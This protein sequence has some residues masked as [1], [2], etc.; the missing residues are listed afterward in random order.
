[1]KTSQLLSFVSAF[2]IFCAAVPQLHAQNGLF[3]VGGTVKDR[4]TGERLEGVYV[5]IPGK[6]VATS[7][8]SDGYFLLKMPAATA[9]KLQFSCIGYM[10]AE[11]DVPS[12]SGTDIAV[13]LR[14]V[15]TVIKTL[16]FIEGDARPLVEKAVSLIGQNYARTDNMLTGFYR[17]TVR[18]RGT[19]VNVSEAVMNIYKTSYGRLLARDRVQV[20]KGR[21]LVSSRLR[22][23][24]SVK[25][26]GGPTSCVTLDLVKSPSHIFS[27]DEMSNYSFR[28]VGS[29]IVDGRDHYCVSFHP[30]NDN[31]IYYGK[32]YIDAENYIISRIIMSVDTDKRDEAT[33]LLLVRKPAGLRFRPDE[34]T[35][36]VAYRQSP[37]GAYL[38]YISTVLRF[39][40]DWRRRLFATTYSVVSEMVTTDRKTEGIENIVSGV[41]FKSR[42][43]LSDHVANFYD[44]EYWQ[45]YN[46]IEPSESL[47]NA[48]NKLRKRS[49][50]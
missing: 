41:D 21:S 48:V 10:V 5:S 45:D 44:E 46:I 32:I 8:N 43:S 34:S 14:P 25:L 7:T 35:V 9:S 18:K 16:K 28:M 6:S 39:R 30:L 49:S 15:S 3:T 38:S 22:D 40:C 42:Y 11:C 1:M 23:T 33:R 17:E 26:Q 47:E 27:P 29:A 2:I 37:E 12:V 19:Y 4:E 13:Y 31:R 50:K 36:T 20:L 24:L